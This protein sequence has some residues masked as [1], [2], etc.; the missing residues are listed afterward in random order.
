MVEEHVLIEGEDSAGWTLHDYVIP[1]LASSV[2][3]AV[4]LP[5]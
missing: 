3:P 4:E 2:I 1:R 5:N